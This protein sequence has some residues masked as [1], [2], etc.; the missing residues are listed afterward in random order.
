[1]LISLAHSPST[2]CLGEP[3]SIWTTCFL[4]ADNHCILNTTLWWKYIVKIFPAILWFVFFHSFNGIFHRASIFTLDEIFY[5]L[6]DCAL[7]SWQKCFVQHLVLK[8]FFFSKRF[9]VLDLC[10]LLIHSELFL[11]FLYNVWDLGQDSVICLG[12]SNCP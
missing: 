2:K 8:I 11:K 7:I 10:T 9:I 6:M 1:M 12:I 4:P 5:F 3:F